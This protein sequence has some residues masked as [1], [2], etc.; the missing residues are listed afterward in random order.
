M[1]GTLRGC[2][3]VKSD[4]FN[5]L[6]IILLSYQLQLL[7]EIIIPHR[8]GYFSDLVTISCFNLLG[9]GGRRWLI[10]TFD[11]FCPKGHGFK[12]YSSRHVRTL[13]KSFT[14]SCLWRF[15]VKL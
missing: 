15:N 14:G 12:S 11:A 8:L 5:K 4:F 10:V 2:S 1:M 9:R 13:G 7:I 6:V 3:M